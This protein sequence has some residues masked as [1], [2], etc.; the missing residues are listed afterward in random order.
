[1]ARSAQKA[2]LSLQDIVVWS[3]LIGSAIYFIAAL[4]SEGVLPAPESFHAMKPNV[5]GSLCYLIGSVAMY[6]DHVKQA[7]TAGARSSASAKVGR[8]V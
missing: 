7:S 1:M 2:A 8:R 4:D 6:L 5:L 3:Y